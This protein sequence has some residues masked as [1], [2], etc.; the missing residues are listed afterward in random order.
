MLPMVVDLGHLQLLVSAVLLLVPSRCPDTRCPE[1][2]EVEVIPESLKQSLEFAQDSA[3]KCQ[4]SSSFQISGFW[5]GFFVGASLVV[6]IISLS[7]CCYRTLLRAVS[8]PSAHEPAR[9]ITS[10]NLR[11]AQQ[12][13]LSLPA[14]AAEVRPA[15]PSDLRALGLA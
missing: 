13:P 1:A 7:Y 9:S 5:L 12:A 6:L 11:L 14:P 15:T 2:K 3:K 8:S 4:Q 10:G